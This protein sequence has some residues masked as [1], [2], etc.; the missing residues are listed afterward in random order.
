MAR[1]LYSPTLISIPIPYPSSLLTVLQSLPF[2]SLDFL[3]LSV[4]MPLPFHVFVSTVFIDS[5]IALTVH[6][7]QT[8]RVVQPFVWFTLSRVLICSGELH[9]FLKHQLVVGIL[10]F[11]L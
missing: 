8:T 4:P 6:L 9:C 10:K 11:D 1:E 2:V 3:S 5:T 7:L